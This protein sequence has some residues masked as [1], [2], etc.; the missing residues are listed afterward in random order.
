ML[1]ATGKSTFKQAGRRSATNTI[2][3]YE[4]EDAH[5]IHDTAYDNS[6]SDR[7]RVTAIAT[8]L[9]TACQR[10]GCPQANGGLPPPQVA[11]H[12]PSVRSRR[13]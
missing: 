10:G 5:G 9:S 12:T 11:L 8:G 2:R 13:R 3:R 1:H 7:L 4:S 6:P